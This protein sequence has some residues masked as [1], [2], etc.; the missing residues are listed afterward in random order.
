MLIFIESKIYVKAL[1]HQ[2]VKD[3]FVVSKRNKIFMLDYIFATC[4]MLLL[5][6]SSVMRKIHIFS[7]C[8]LCVKP[9]TTIY[10]RITSIALILILEK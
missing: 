8:D 6:C 7:I 10:T 4:V 1:V 2:G 5:L 9:S 3:E